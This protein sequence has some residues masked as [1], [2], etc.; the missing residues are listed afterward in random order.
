MT[1]TVMPAD[2]I[3]ALKPDYVAPLVG[4]LCHE[5]STT[6]GGLF[7]VGAGWVGRLRWERTKGHVFDVTKMTPESIRDQWED[8]NNWSDSTHPTSTEESGAVIFDAMR[9][10]KEKGTAKL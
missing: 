7:E 3:E 6:T 4:Y 5:S 1:E 10:I 8:V 9:Q 2:F